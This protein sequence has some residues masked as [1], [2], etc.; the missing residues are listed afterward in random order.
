MIIPIRCMTCGKPIADLWNYY[1]N[2]INKE[3]EPEDT[4]NINSKKIEK[5]HRGKVMDQLELKRYC[6]RKH[7]LTHSDLIDII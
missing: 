1:Q 6:C 5:T 3:K 7:L 2:E 4:I